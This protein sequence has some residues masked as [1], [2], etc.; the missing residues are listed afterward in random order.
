LKIHKSVWFDLDFFQYFF[1]FRFLLFHESGFRW[2][3]SFFCL[4][5]LDW[6]CHKNKE[7]TCLIIYY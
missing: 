5:W 1:R 4:I 6:L 2:F 7:I 3:W